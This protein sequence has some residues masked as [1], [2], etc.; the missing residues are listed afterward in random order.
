[1]VEI[2]I[3]L[4]RGKKNTC[5][6]HN[7]AGYEVVGANEAMMTLHFR[8]WRMRLLHQPCAATRRLQQLHAANAVAQPSTSNDAAQVGQVNVGRSK[9]RNEVHDVGANVPMSEGQQRDIKIFHTSA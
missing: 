3:L 1:M 4:A 6:M 2:P 5:V 7:T 9:A 8:A